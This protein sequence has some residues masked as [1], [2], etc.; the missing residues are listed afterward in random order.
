MGKGELQERRENWNSLTIYIFWNL[1][2]S[3]SE[4][5]HLHKSTDIH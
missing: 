1:K 3:N 5:I 4:K 2:N